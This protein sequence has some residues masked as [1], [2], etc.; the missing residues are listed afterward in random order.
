MRAQGLIE[1]IAFPAGL[2]DKYQSYTQADIGQLREAG[3]AA[4]VPDRGAGRGALCRMD[5]CAMTAL[6]G[7]K[8][9]AFGRAGAGVARPS[10]TSSANTPLVR[11][12][13][14]GRARP[15]TSLLAKLE[16][17]NPAGS[18]KDRP[19]LSMIAQPRRAATSSRATR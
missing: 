16:G 13:A 14:H 4:A 7:G 15:A 3:Y 5:G 17:N 6:K 9:Q 10:R 12:Q 8:S 18:V 2:K 19:A 1:Y 11:L